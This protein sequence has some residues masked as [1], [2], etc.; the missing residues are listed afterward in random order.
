MEIL[1]LSEYFKTMRTDGFAE[2]FRMQVELTR[3][4]NSGQ[5][6]SHSEMLGLFSEPDGQ[7]KVPMW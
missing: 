2:I 5:P 3:F 6:V 1:S 7:M 4:K